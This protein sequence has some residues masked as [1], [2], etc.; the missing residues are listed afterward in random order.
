MTHAWAAGQLSPWGRP[1]RGS[2]PGSVAGLGGHRFPEWWEEKVLE[3]SPGS[4][5]GELSLECPPAGPNTPRFCPDSGLKNV[6]HSPNEGDGSHEGRGP[7]VTPGSCDTWLWPDPRACGQLELPDAPSALE[8][9]IFLQGP[10]QSPGHRKKD[11]FLE[12]SL[13]S[14]GSDDPIPSCPLTR[15]GKTVGNA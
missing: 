2:G 14:K 4:W 11:L 13:R 6:H 9:Y 10:W 12:A 15:A 1:S 3:G 8:M 5:Q 7:G